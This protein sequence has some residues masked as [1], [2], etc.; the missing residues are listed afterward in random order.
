[1]IIVCLSAACAA[2]TF[3]A[4]AK[5]K[6]AAAPQPAPANAA[7]SPNQSRRAQGEI[8]RCMKET[9][10]S[11]EKLKKFQKRYSPEIDIETL[12]TEREALLKEIHDRTVKLNEL[13]E[14]F[15]QIKKLEQWHMG[16]Q[17]L[18]EIVSGNKARPS[19]TEIETVF[20][21]D[22]FAKDI[23]DFKSGVSQAIVQEDAAWRSIQQSQTDKRWVIF[24]SA[25]AAGGL[26]AFAFFIWRLKRRRQALTMTAV[27]VHG[28]GGRAAPPSL[29]PA[30]TPG[31]PLLGWPSTPTPYPRP[32]TSTETAGAVGAVIGGNYRIDSQIGRGAMATVYEAY[33]IE[34]NRKVV[35]KQVREEVHQS[36][37]DVERF[38]ASARTVTTLKHPSLA[39]IFSIFLEGERIYMIEEYCPGRPLS[40][41]LDAGKRISMRSIKGVLQQV[42]AAVDHA[43]LQGIIHGDLKPSNI[44]VSPQ[45]VV[46]V[47]DFSISLQAKKT[48]AK[49]SWAEARG[50]PPY[51]AP[52][53][54]LGMVV[55]ASDLYSLGVMLYEM[56][57]G[58]LP[59]EGPNFLAQKREMSFHPPTKIVPELPRALDIVVKKALQPDPP[60]RFQKAAD[61]FGAIAVLPD[62]PA[63]N[64]PRTQTQG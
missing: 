35:L 4:P 6:R 41:F 40:R 50:S 44:I 17:V 5:P 45:G 64:P 62:S 25:G 16:T 26:I 10:G 9:E 52:E 54:E 48:M 22:N 61:L 13:E 57:T 8:E 14:S 43:H 60:A 46:K 38:L 36:E 42:A 49:L 47:M 59:F 31:M 33:D 21:L 34:H 27:P 11:V 63:T 23:R 39:E 58:R 19:A 37:K 24:I 56:S 15:N 2:G 28:P 55:P 3:A 1:M 32:V 20:N 12:R 18:Q 53:Q 7:P 29:I 30:Q 51:M